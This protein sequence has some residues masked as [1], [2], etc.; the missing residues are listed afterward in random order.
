MIEKQILDLH[1]SGKSRSAIS[2]L[3]RCSE[4]KVR[5]TIRA[6]ITKN[7]QAKEYKQPVGIRLQEVTRSSAGLKKAVIL[8]DIHIPHH[9][10][11]AL[12]IAVEFMKDYAPNTIIL[13]GD[14]VDFYAVSSYRKDTTRIDTLQDELNETRSFL[15]LVR[16]NHP[17]ARIVFL[18]GNHSSRLA[19][20]LL[21]KAPELTSLTCLAL[22]EL[23]DLKKLNIEHVEY[24]D[25]IHLGLLEITHGE[26]S[27][28]GSGASVKAHMDKSGGSVLIGH[29]HKLSMNHKTNKW[30]IH[31]G[32]ENGHLARED[33]EYVSFP[34]WQQGF[35][36]CE[37]LESTGD[38]YPR[39]HN[40]RNGKLIVDGILY[41]SS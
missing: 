40:I 25:S 1:K 11:S 36:S 31:V 37:W 23:L 41:A 38:F 20:F 16:A 15:E 18:Q 9:S 4:W 12:A 27:R 29:V 33:V 34:D 39:L 8:S 32:I 28:K 3:L 10:Q 13:N 6:Q 7:V 24:G 21:D 2:K 14:L 35:T 5:T 17:S 22:D 26:L 30:G 19:R